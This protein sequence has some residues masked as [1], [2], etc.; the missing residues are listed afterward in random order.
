M[1]QIKPFIERDPVTPEFQ[2]FSIWS[3]AS[4]VNVVVVCVCVVVGGGGGGGK[5]ESTSVSCSVKVSNL[6]WF[7][8]TTWLFEYIFDLNWVKMPCFPDLC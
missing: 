4:K 6:W 3:I 5:E 2:E 8:T 1:D 7:H